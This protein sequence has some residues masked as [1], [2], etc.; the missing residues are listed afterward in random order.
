MSIIASPLI[1]DLQFYLSGPMPCPYLQGRIERK[2]FTR[3]KKGEDELN[4][5]INGALCRAGFRRSHDVV[6][7][8]ACEFCN[9]CIPVRIPVHS[10]IP[11]RSMKRVIA[12]N[13]DLNWRQSDAVPSAELF[14]LFSFYQQSRHG[15][16][17]MANM[18]YG[19]FAAMLEEGQAGTRLYLLHDENEILQGCMISDFV[20]DGLSAVYSFFAP[21]MPKRSLGIFMILSLVAEAQK[22]N[23]P[24][25]YLGYWVAEARKMA[26]KSRFQ[27]MQYLGSHGWEWMA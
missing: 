17:D 26:Y 12:Q 15:D 22:Q 24:F 19:E 7:R 8:P 6:Y 5:G 2:L 20:G 18:T 14:A 4:E 23:W 13:H 1:R 16:S 10:F 27:P 3:L 11:T 25:V 21:D 9:A